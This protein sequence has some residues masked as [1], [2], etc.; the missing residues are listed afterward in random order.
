MRLTNRLKA[1]NTSCKCRKRISRPERS[2]RMQVSTTQLTVE[3]CSHQE[4]NYR[5]SSSNRACSHSTMTRPRRRK[6]PTAPAHHSQ[7][8]RHSR[9]RRFS[10]HAVKDLRPNSRATSQRNSWMTGSW[11]NQHPKWT[12]TPPPS[13]KA[14]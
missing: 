7:T 10:H 12:S 2:S 4:S 14:R 13:Q 5:L 8:S 1:R 9:E 11:S 6:P 3:A